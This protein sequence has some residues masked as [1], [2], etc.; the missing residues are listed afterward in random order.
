[1][2]SEYKFIPMITRQIVALNVVNYKAAVMN[3]MTPFVQLH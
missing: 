2:F 1:M 3:L